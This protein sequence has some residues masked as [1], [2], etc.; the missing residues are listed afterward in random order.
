MDQTTKSHLSAGSRFKRID[1]ITLFVEEL[2]A[3]RQFYQQVF[4][5]PIVFE[6]ND[7]TVFK[8][9]NTLVNLL[10]HTAAQELIEPVRVASRESGARFVFTVEVD[11]VDALC[12]D[13][14]ARGV[15]LLN[16]P[17]DRPWGV[18]TASFMD[19]GGHIWEIA[20]QLEV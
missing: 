17:I 19:P 16:G 10:K 5:L 15:E 1:T 7:S 12:A 13:L 11:D 4:S 20:K 14:A 8:F 2:E 6:D 9:G 3:T 18:R